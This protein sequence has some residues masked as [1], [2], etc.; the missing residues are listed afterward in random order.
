MPVALVTGARGFLGRHLA[1]TLSNTG[2]VVLGVGHGL[3]PEAQSHGLTFWLG[4]EIDETNLDIVS[5]KARPDVVYH[6]AGGSSVAPSF[7]AP[8]EDFHRTVETTAR[9]LDWVR[10]RTPETRVVFVSSA[11]VYGAN[12]TGAIA[13][14]TIPSPVSPYGAHKFMAEQLLRSYT[15][16]FGLRTAIVRL[17]SVYGPGLRK[18]LIW[19]LCS[20]LALGPAELT[21]AGSGMEIRDWLYVQDAVNL[22]ILAATQASSNCSTFNGGTGTPITVCDLATCVARLWGVPAPM[23]SGDCR[24]GDPLSLLANI[25]R[26]ARIGFQPTVSLKQGLSNT[27]Q[28]FQRTREHR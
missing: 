24:P 26:A 11:A 28:W 8:F 3:W 14:D 16:N 25:D 6:L 17:F 22:L 27:V 19:D 23:F 18:Q 9:L 5:S 4:G 7:Q 10:R 1:Q 13:E 2:V 21:L 15:T 12:H 20:R